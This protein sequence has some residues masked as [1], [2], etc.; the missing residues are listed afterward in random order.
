MSVTHFIDAYKGKPPWDIGRP[1]PAFEAL[2]DA[3]EI[4]GPVLDAGCGTGENALFLAAR[5]FEVV[6]VDAV[7]AAVEAARRKALARGLEAEFLVHDALA[8]DGLGRRFATVVD[9]GLFHTFDD[10]ERV[11]FVKSLAAALTLGGR[12]YVLCFSERE[13]ARG[14]PAP[15]HSGRAARGLRP[16]AVS[17]ALHRGGGDGH[18]PRRWRPQGLAG[19]H[20]T[21][22]ERRSRRGAGLRVRAPA[23]ACRAH[24]RSM[25]WRW[26][27]AASASGNSRATTGA[28]SRRA[29]R[30][31][32]PRG[33]RRLPPVDALEL[34]MPRTGP[35]L[36]MR[37]RGSTVTVPRLPTTTTRPRMARA[38]RSSPR[39][40]LASSSMM[41]SKPRPPVVVDGRA[42]VQRVAV[43]DGGTRA[44]ARDQLA[45]RF[46]AGGADDA[47]G[48]RPAR[49]G[50]PRDPRRR[51]RRVR[52]RSRRRRR[53]AR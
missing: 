48:R 15:R 30:S 32:W 37:S 14:R 2:A 12:Y 53:W 29:G 4:A 21:G 26:A 6:G 41:T 43:V 34:S 7:E 44:L 36:F 52:V 10:R 11:R 22:G 8:L 23:R 17:R 49:T 9:S 38:V 46:A 24:G 31:R 39:L 47:S 33:S 40:T 42:Q 45:A 5:G 18:Q 25:T 16:A 3:G 13:L 1:Q 27:R 35:P 50:R 20:R 28:A 51:W 19:A